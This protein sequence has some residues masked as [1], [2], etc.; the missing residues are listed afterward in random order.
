MNKLIKHEFRATARMI[1]PFLAVA[2]FSAILF[3]FTNRMEGFPNALTV[4]FIMIISVSLMALGVM[5]VVIVISRFY[6]NVMTDT[7]YL[8]MTLPLNA[9]EFIWAELIMC[10]CWFIIVAVVLAAALLCSMAVGGLLSLPDSFGEIANFFRSLNEAFREHGVSAFMIALV[11]LEGIIAAILAFFGFCLRFY[12]CMSVGQLFS[13]NRE[14]FSVI[15]Y[16]LIGVVTSVLFTVIMKIF[17]GTLSFDAD[18]IVK[19]AGAIGLFDM[20]LLIIDAALYAPTA[21]VL[22]KRLNLA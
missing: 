20:T 19:A 18:T 21:L 14:L 17:V 13:H 22:D 5:G 4:I 3:S 8:T 6:R 16:V 1:I 11:I 9:H 12:C 2:V 7:G 15:A 10:L